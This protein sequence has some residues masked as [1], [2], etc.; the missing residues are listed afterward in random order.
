[1]LEGGFDLLALDEADLEGD[2]GD[3]LDDLR[4]N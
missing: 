3:L 1:L 2:D 4:A